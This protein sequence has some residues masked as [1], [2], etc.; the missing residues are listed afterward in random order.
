MQTNASML[1]SNI[2]TSF[3]ASANPELIEDA[4]WRFRKNHGEVD[5]ERRAWL[6]ERCA[7]AV[8]IACRSSPLIASDAERWRVRIELD[9]F[10]RERIHF[11]EESK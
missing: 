4:Y 7:A 5:A 1:D 8:V 3:G 11:M 2:V 9:D 6:F 10:M